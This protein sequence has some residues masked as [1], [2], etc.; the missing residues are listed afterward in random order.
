MEIVKSNK[1]EHDPS[2]FDSDEE[3]PNAD[4][5]FITDDQIAQLC[6]NELTVSAGYNDDDL[7]G[8]RKKALDYYFGRP[9]GDELEGRASSQSMDV[10]DMTEAT[11]AEIMPL[12][13]SANI[14]TFSAVP[15]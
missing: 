1:V 14:A 11:L 6:Y 8:N 2:F 7:S 3:M 9:R 10:A 4:D 13:S 12:F 5:P 15:R